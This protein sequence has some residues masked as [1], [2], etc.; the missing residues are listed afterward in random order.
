MRSSFIRL[1]RVS[2]LPSPSPAKSNAQPLNST[3]LA[4]Y[5]AHT[6]SQSTRHVYGTFREPL[7]V[8]DRADTA[9]STLGREA[10]DHLVSTSTPLPKT[11]SEPSSSGHK[12]AN[13]GESSSDGVELRTK[14]RV[15]RYT[16]DSSFASTSKHSITPTA[17]SLLDA[18]T[19]QLPSTE[20]ELFTLL[21]R[22]GSVY[23]K[24]E[25]TWLYQFHAHPRLR[26]HVSTRT[27]SFVLTAA[28]R[29]NDAR[30]VETILDEMSERSIKWDRDLGRVLLR[31]Y[32]MTSQEDKWRE[33][34][35]KL[36][37][38]PRPEPARNH[39]EWVVEGRYTKRISLGA[40][41]KGKA[42]EGTA[43]LGGEGVGWKG[44]SLRARDREQQKLDAQEQAQLE[45][46]K[47]A[48][49][50]SLDHVVRPKKRPPARTR[51][52]LPSSKLRPR[53]LI[54]PHFDRLSS[55]TISDLVQLLVQDQRREEALSLAAAWL[56]ANRPNLE[57]PPNTSD[58]L[59]RQ[60]HVYNATLVV[61][62]N[63]LLKPLLLAQASASELVAFI[64][65]F[66]SRH[67]P[68]A[69]LP[70]PLPRLSTLRH[71][72]SALTGKKN[73]WRDGKRIVDH[74]GYTWGL[75]IGDAGFEQRQH[76]MRFV[77]RRKNDPLNRQSTIS[78]SVNDLAETMQ[79]GL[80]VPPHTVAPP[81]IAVLL[82]RLAVDTHA[83]EST[84]FRPSEI[85]AFRHWWKSRL[86]AEGSSDWYRGQ[87]VRH[88]LI[89]AGQSGLLNKYVN[90]RKRKEWWDLNVGARRRRGKSRKPSSR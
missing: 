71:I 79:D 26:P 61:L 11:S 47:T 45:N 25:S 58:T 89:Q 3:R 44:W 29:D 1:S 82:L 35:R 69:S 77:P 87:T 59:I 67:A 52:I 4:Q 53:V 46:L 60:G 34:L 17:T 33:V 12:R 55:S 9:A 80:S 27:Y 54:P 38:E 19:S 65:T 40:K 70:Q 6:L 84:R 39:L 14:S 62:L 23:P 78:Q 5:A 50:S 7:P 32:R 16:A 57:Q 88:L 13:P 81:S 10:S 41:G 8:P 28:F 64:S 20:S 56:D 74:F 31:G 75:P 66:L 36:E 73:A 48:S 18:D 76:R 2:H 68:P 42:K 51:T 21:R 83:T 49:S 15:P 24:I 37:G 22:I 86:E 30:L 72:L 85:I 43:G 63:I 90:S